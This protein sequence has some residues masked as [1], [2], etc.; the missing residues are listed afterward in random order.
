MPGRAC[1]RRT[2]SSQI[3]LPRINHDM[4][5]LVTTRLAAVYVAGLRNGSADR[6]SE[7]QRCR[8]AAVEELPHITE[9]RSEKPVFKDAVK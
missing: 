6:P 8:E 1:A 3:R 9:P 2:G 5:H 7:L 4:W